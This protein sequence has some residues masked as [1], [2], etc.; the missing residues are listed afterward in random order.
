MADPSDFRAEMG[1]DS[2]S[3][4][5]SN[6]GSDREEEGSSVVPE[7]SKMVAVPH[8]TESVGP[9]SGEVSLVVVRRDLSREKSTSL[10]E[11]VDD[12]WDSHSTEVFPMVSEDEQPAPAVEVNEFLAVEP[13]KPHIF[14]LSRKQLY[15][16]RYRALAA[17]IIFVSLSIMFAVIGTQTFW[18]AR[19]N[20]STWF[21]LFSIITM[22]S[23]LVLDLWNV[24]LTFFGINT[25][26]LLV[27]IISI[28]EALAGFSN[29]GIL[30]TAIMFI[31]SKAIEKTG[32]LEWVVRNVLR[33][34]RSVRSA[35]LRMLPAVAIWSCWVRKKKK[36]VLLVKTY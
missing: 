29:E 28:K 35:M 7:P 24:S 5:S 36:S 6:S 4:S 9:A 16:A 1:F 15:D 22:L 13:N 25:I 34:P 21:T 17:V 30:S 14:G 31:I 32:V 23:V 11:F 20:W 19:M 33:R 8:S 12:F 10:K 18:R 27:R 2:S 3:S 26:L